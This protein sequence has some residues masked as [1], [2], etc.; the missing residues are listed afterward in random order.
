MGILFNLNITYMTSFDSL[1]S[2]IAQTLLRTEWYTLVENKQKVTHVEVMLSSLQLKRE[3]HQRFIK[4]TI[5]NIHNSTMTQ[6][7]HAEVEKVWNA[8]GIH[9]QAPCYPIFQ[10]CIKDDRFCWR[11]KVKTSVKDRLIQPC[12]KRD[13]R[14]KI[15]WDQA[16]LL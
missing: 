11:N 8:V 14:S 13:T 3:N 2:V 7:L 5:F 16:S 15:G 12:I 6:I 10:I 4:H 1:E 9:F